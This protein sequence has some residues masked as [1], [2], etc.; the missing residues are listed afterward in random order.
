MKITKLDSRAKTMRIILFSILTFAL[1]LAAAE[2][3][4]ADALVVWSK[5]PTDPNPAG[6]QML[7][8]ELAGKAMSLSVRLRAS[9]ATGP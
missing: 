5:N 2:K 4:L 9:A 7:P 3:P 8:K 1:A 6:A